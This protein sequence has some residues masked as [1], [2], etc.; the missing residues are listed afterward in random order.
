[1]HLRWPLVFRWYRRKKIQSKKIFVY[2]IK[3][4]NARNTKVCQWR[5][6]KSLQH[7]LHLCNLFSWSS[8]TLFTHL[9]CHLSGCFHRGFITK[10]LCAFLISTI[11]VKKSNH[12]DCDFTILR[13]SWGY[14]L[15]SALR[16][17]LASFV[18]DPNIYKHLQIFAIFVIPS[19]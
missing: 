2:K 10:I 1:M 18:F 13:A 7:T 8:S 6:F 12:G 16:S 9:F 19:E 14:V 5:G 3:R 4:L 11:T 15:C 17:P